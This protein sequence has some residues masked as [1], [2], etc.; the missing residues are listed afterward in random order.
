MGVG[1]WNGSILAAGSTQV[2]E[3]MLSEWVKEKAV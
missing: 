3:S 1:K 2:G